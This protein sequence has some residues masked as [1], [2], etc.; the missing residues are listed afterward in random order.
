MFWKMKTLII[1]LY[2]AGI[3][4]AMTQEN[5]KIEVIEKN[6]KAYNSKISSG[7]GSYV[8]TYKLLSDSRY[9][10]TLKN[11]QSAL[12]QGL[13]VTRDIQTEYIYKFR[14]ES[15]HFISINQKTLRKERECFYNGKTFKSIVYA[16]K[17][18]LSNQTGQVYNNQ[19]IDRFHEHP[20]EIVNNTVLKHI[21]GYRSG[22]L[23]ID[24]KE[25]QIYN[26][27]EYLVVTF[28][29]EDGSTSFYLDAQSY[30][31]YRMVQV[32]GENE[33]KNSQ[34]IVIEY[35]SIDTILFPK[36][37]VVTYSQ[38]NE[39]TIEKDIAFNED[40]KLNIPIDEPFDITFPKGMEVIDGILGKTY[41]VE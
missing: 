26:N 11:V 37:I 40:W 27:K 18:N 36:H 30:R 32:N 31:F 25:K 34:E 2:L 15:Y 14:D 7:S 16:Y 12:G 9:N 10:E 4:P 3:L 6:I 28:Y 13:T 19:R 39:V 21:N 41:I 33:R 1:V 24:I 35:Q 20:L 5:N 8:Y 29:A 17:N 38:N 22:N 23:S